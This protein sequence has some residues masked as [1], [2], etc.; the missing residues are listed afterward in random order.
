MAV[1]FSRACE[2]ALR[3][4]F[5]MARHPEHDNWTVQELAQRV[6][7]PAPFLAKTFQT[8]VKGRI[9]IS[10][11]G[12]TGGFIFARKPATISLLQVVEIIDGTSLSKD[13]ALGLPAC[14]E[15]NP[16]PFHSHW[17]GVREAIIDAL[18]SESLVQV[19]EKSSIA[20]KP[21]TRRS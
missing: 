18:R 19:A 13:C 5:E 9:L 3:A 6:E 11:K 15:T 4:L 1:V 7:I 8:L 21:A 16:C 17:K 2:Y 20:A 12:R 14:S 10:S